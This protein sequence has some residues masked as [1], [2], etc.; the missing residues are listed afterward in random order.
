M[1]NEPARGPQYADAW[2]VLIALY[3]AYRLGGASGLVMYKV[4]FAGVLLAILGF[5]LRET[6][7]SAGRSHR[8]SRASRCSCTAGT[9]RSARCCSAR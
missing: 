1:T 3:L 4:I 5:A 7:A 8:S 9:A 2:A 6:R